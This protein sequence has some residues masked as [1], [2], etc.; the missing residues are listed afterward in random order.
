M[1]GDEKCVQNSQIKLSAIS[2]KQYIMNFT[3]CYKGTRS[4]EKPDEF[5]WD[6]NEF[7]AHQ[8]K[9]PYLCEFLKGNTGSNKIKP[10]F[11][12]ESDETRKRGIFSL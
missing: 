10:F 3:N 2:K 4:G 9:Y 8:V 5:S 1:R 7:Y 11:D 12:F 6:L